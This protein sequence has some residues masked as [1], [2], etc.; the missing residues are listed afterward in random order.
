MVLIGCRNV[1]H[2]YWTLRGREGRGK[3]AWL[4]RSAFKSLHHSSCGTSLGKL[5]Q[6]K[7]MVS[8]VNVMSL[9]I[10]MMTRSQ[11]NIITITYP[12]TPNNQRPLPSNSIW[13]NL[14][15]WAFSSIKTWIRAGGGCQ[16]LSAVSVKACRSAKTNFLLYS[17]D[18]SDKF[19]TG[20]L[21]GG[22]PVIFCTL[23]T[24]EVTLIRIL[25]HFALH[26]WLLQETGIQGNV[27][28]NVMKMSPT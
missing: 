23:I 21:S 10:F 26:K 7:L 2:S 27:D 28:L 16:C 14:L 17:S 13:L 9:I 25:Q 19:C 6:L 20:C 22:E 1:P 3:V 18:L 15:Y 5:A 8:A 11:N 24:I 12:R 4:R